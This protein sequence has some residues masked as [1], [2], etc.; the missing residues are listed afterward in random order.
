MSMTTLRRKY[1]PKVER[2]PSAAKAAIAAV[3]PRDARGHFL[4]V[5]GDA[6]RPAAVRGS[7]ETGVVDF[8]A[9]NGAEAV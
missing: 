4:P 7:G 1:L 6:V 3:R 8:V 9:E 2:S 5:V